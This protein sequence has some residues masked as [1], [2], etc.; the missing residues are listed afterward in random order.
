MPESIRIRLFLTCWLVYV[1]HFATDF[2]REHYL[3]VSMVEDHTYVLDKYFGMHDDI[4]QNPTSARVAGAHHGANPGISMVAAIPYFV[5][6]P[7][8]DWVV[9]R[10]L[11]ARRSRGDSSATYQDRRSKRVEFYQKVRRMGL[12]IRFGV[13]EAITSFFVMAPLSALSAVLMYSLLLAMGLTRRVAL[14]LSL[15]YAFGTPTFFRTAYLNQNLGLGVSAFAAF[16]IIWNPRELVGWRVRTRYLVAGLLG[17]FA[18]LCD[19]SGAILMGLLGFYAWWHRAE[20]VGIRAGFRGSLWYLAGTVPGILCLWQYQWASFGNPF[21]PPQHWMAPVEWIDIGYKGVGGFS[22]EL[23][24][25]LLIDGR[26]G[27]LIA[28]PVAVLALLAPWLARRGR[29]PL[30]GREAVTCL[31]LSAALIGFFST[32][33]YTRLQWV[34]GIR[35]LAPLFPFLFLAA[36]PALLWLPRIVTY[37]L[38]TIS[39]VI[40]WSIAMVRSQGTILE[41]VQRV[42]VEGFQLPWLTV[43]TK[44]SAQY[45]PWYRGVV[46]PLPLFLVWGG[47]IWM[48]W[49]VRSPWRGL[50]SGD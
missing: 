27:L 40:S 50:N 6:R 15:L 4:F 29:S 47:L 44:M 37:G 39:V 1:L 31:V 43:L 42:F 7:G 8:V 22:G 23:L 46:S 17:G 36:V 20:E 25:M 28:M 21:L 13:I 24:R 9:N 48:I 5:L 49:R 3:V 2:V 38:A 32:V 14:G 34:T 30:P 45:L 11:A 18:F 16:A 33:Q 10:E 35:Y 12:D 41:N 26:F 19:Y